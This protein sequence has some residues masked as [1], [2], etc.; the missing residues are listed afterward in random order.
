M[1]DMK[2]IDPFQKN[3]IFSEKDLPDGIKKVIQINKIMD[4]MKNP[5]A[6]ITLYKENENNH[7]IFKK[8]GHCFSNR[9]R[10]GMFNRLP[11]IMYI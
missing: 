7:N 1:A 5:S 9:V 2:H 8:I 3:E 4:I 11:Q 6:E 10:K